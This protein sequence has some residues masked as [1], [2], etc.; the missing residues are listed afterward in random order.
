M[1]ATSVPIPVSA[2]TTPSGKEFPPQAP[3]EAAPTTPEMTRID[4]EIC[5]SF[6]GSS[7]FYGLSW[8]LGAQGAFQMATPGNTIRFPSTRSEAISTFAIDASLFS[9][10]LLQ[11]SFF[12]TTVPPPD[13]NEPS[14]GG[15]VECRPDKS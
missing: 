2:G 11:A 12:G 15:K 7:E 5:G 1:D 8:H 9:A 14:Q 6:M 10:C 4:F 3:R 13:T